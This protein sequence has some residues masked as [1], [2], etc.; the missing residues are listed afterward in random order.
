MKILVIN[1]GSSSLKYQLFEMD[2]EKVLA[3]GIVERIGINGSVLTHKVGSEKFIKETPMNNHT[4]AIKYVI[5]ALVDKE[6]GVISHLSEINAVGHRVVHGGERYSKSAIVNDEVLSDLE[7]LSKLAPLHNPANI[8]GIK[9]CRELMPNVPM[10][11]V[12]DTSFHQT[13]PKNAYMYAIPYEIYEKYGVRKYGFH[14]TSHDYVAHKAAE[15]LG[16][17]I[18]DLKIITCHLGNGSSLCAVDGGKSIDTSMGFTPLEGIAMGTRS[19]DIDPAVIPFLVKET[20]KDIDEILNILNKQ[21]G[22]LGLSGVSSDFRDIEAAKDEGNERA[23]LALEVFCYRVKK[24]I[25]AYIAALGGIDVIVFTAGVGENGPYTRKECCRGLEFLGIKLD[26]ELNKV[27]GELKEIS[28]EDSKVK[29]LV[30]PTDEELMIARDTK[31][32]TS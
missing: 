6:H 20:G 8:I 12:F 19:G 26:D 25:G 9:A 18:E 17:N 21:S 3:K 13:M 2:N 29:V 10:V 27:R 7:D 32:L 5:E 4:D 31:A 1:C 23:K 15:F 16:K 11:I 28:T 22:V 14:G 30:V 24:Y